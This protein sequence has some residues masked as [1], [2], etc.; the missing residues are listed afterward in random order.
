VPEEAAR[1]RSIDIR[2]IYRWIETGTIHVIEV[3]EGILVCLN[4]IASIGGN[5]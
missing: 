5:K 2:T 3:S 1:R 4:S